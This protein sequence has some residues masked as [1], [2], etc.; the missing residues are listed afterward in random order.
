MMI[1]RCDRSSWNEGVCFYASV[2]ILRSR[3]G[4]LLFDQKLV[5]GSLPGAYR[6]ADNWCNPARKAVMAC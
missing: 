5:R 2:V 6:A 4:D 1:F 3:G